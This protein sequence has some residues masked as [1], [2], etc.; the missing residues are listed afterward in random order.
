[1]GLKQRLVEPE[2]L[3][4]LPAT[5]PLAVGARNDLRRMN[6]HMRS[7]EILARELKP[8]IERSAPRTVVEL[9]AGDGTLLLDIA[10]RLQAK[11]GAVEAVLLDRQDLLAGD[12]AR[13]FELLGW[14]VRTLKTDLRDWLHQPQPTYDFTLA[15]L[16][17]HHFKDEELR[18]LMPG[19]AARTSMFLA[20]EPRRCARFL[21]VSKLLW[22]FRCNRVTRNDAQVSVRAGFSNRELTQHWPRSGWE[23]KETEAGW[24][25]H[26]F[27][28]ARP[29]L[30]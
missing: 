11:W 28:A 5:H 10:R 14:H 7:A 9:G 13:S 26:L 22:F 8:H 17:L 1:M 20:L 3:D 30:E 15:N 2:L 27:I 29:E 6:A 23:V 21:L 19:I 16:F 12:T 18:Q 4:E 24:F 25:S